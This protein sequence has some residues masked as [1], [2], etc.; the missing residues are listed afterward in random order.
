M[1]TPRSFRPIVRQVVVKASAEP[2]QRQNLPGR[3]A[4]SSGNW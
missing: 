4:G 1:H 2:A 3:K